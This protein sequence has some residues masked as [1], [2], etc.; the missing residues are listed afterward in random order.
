MHSGN[1]SMLSN[2]YAYDGHYNRHPVAFKDPISLQ[3]YMNQMKAEICQEYGMPM[4]INYLRYK[5]EYISKTPE[6]VDRDYYSGLVR[7]ENDCFSYNVVDSMYQETGELDPS[8]IILKLCQVCYKGSHKFN[9]QEQGNKKVRIVDFV[10]N[11]KI[12]FRFQFECANNKIANRA[13]ALES[14]FFLFPGVFYLILY[15]TVRKSDPFDIVGYASQQSSLKKEDDKAKKDND[16]Y[17]KLFDCTI[18]DI[19]RFDKSDTM[20]GFKTNSQSIRT[21]DQSFTNKVKSKMFSTLSNTMLQKVAGRSL[22][23]EAKLNKKV[24]A[25][26][27][28][29][30]EGKNEYTVTASDNQ[31]NK[32]FTMDVICQNKA[33]AKAICG[34]KFIELHSKEIFAEIWRQEFGKEM[35]QKTNNSTDNYTMGESRFFSQDGTE[36]VYDDMVKRMGAGPP[37]LSRIDNFGGKE[38]YNQESFQSNKNFLE[39]INQA[40]DASLAMALHNTSGIVRKPLNVK[41]A[42]I[43]PF[44]DQLP[45][46]N[47]AYRYGQTENETEIGDALESQ[48]FRTPQLDQQKVS[49]ES[50]LIKEK[51]EKEV[52]H[53]FDDTEDEFDDF[54]RRDFREKLPQVTS[55]PR[56]DPKLAGYQV[57]GE[58]KGNRMINPGGKFKIGKAPKD[59][60]DDPDSSDED[61]T[62]SKDSDL[63]DNKSKD[64]LGESEPQ[65][66]SFNQCLEEKAEENF[67][68]LEKVM[69]DYMESTFQFQGEL[70]VDAFPKGLQYQAPGNCSYPSLFEGNF[71]YRVNDLLQNQNESRRIVL[72]PLTKDDNC[73]KIRYVFEETVHGSDPR[74]LHYQDLK[75]TSGNL[76]FDICTNFGIFLILRRSVPQLYRRICSTTVR[77]LLGL[78]QEDKASSFLIKSQVPRFS[79]KATL[80]HND[81]LSMISHIPGKRSS[82]NN[83]LGQSLTMN[84]SFNGPR[85]VLKEFQP[86][87]GPS[88][89]LDTQGEFRNA[90]SPGS[91]SLVPPDYTQ[92]SQGT[93]PFS[94]TPGFIKQMEEF[95][96]YKRLPDKLKFPQEAEEV[97]KWDRLKDDFNKVFGPKLGLESWELTDVYFHEDLEKKKST[98]VNSFEH[99]IKKKESFYS[100]VKKNLIDEDYAS[101]LNSLIHT[102]FKEPLKLQQEGNY[103]TFALASRVLVIINAR[104]QNN[105]LRNKLASMV[106]IRLLW[107]EFYT[108]CTV[109]DLSRKDN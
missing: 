75:F 19:Q 31:A 85:S 2:S 28:L 68:T 95:L 38:D 66:D 101:V 87:S 104:V 92:Y 106:L 100:N 1:S 20:A 52:G 53:L 13:T 108:R 78:I 15:T 10:L 96:R 27:T 82:H 89:E 18:V 33:D 17:A 77:S 88:R 50:N 56:E 99:R 81:D 25:S 54:D 35:A 63:A 36:E 94:I 45:S 73:I 67:D 69:E 90:Q 12:L 62:L 80:A 3:R 79:T 43:S 14:I 41:S 44:G 51:L 42:S 58:S 46:S 24:S 23:F 72:F 26:N 74:T 7:P 103:T 32:Y 60:K 59:H 30:G 39:G 109:G 105:K 29:E 9:P 6:I 86:T 5:N 55:W 83:L 37:G 48:A 11:N 84:D 47:K 61:D 76:D 107:E 65:D 70:S 34:L 22:N 16:I 49:N 97:Q 8:K 71:P 93:E 64:D 98:R 40:D 91:R 57:F 102:I 21:L 4:M